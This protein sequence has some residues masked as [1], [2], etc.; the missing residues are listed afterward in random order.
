[1]VDLVV[2]NLVA[3]NAMAYL[4]AAAGRSLL[5]AKNFFYDL[6]FLKNYL[7]GLESSVSAFTF[8]FKV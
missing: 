1:L 8:R 2:G 4:E 6:N 5:K 7:A 3:R